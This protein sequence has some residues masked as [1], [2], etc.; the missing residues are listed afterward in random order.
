MHFFKIL[1]FI[2]VIVSAALAIPAPTLDTDTP[3]KGERD[4]ICLPQI[5]SNVGNVMASLSADIRR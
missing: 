4:L 2:A 3:L 5:I 1:S